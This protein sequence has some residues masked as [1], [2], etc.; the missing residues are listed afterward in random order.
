MTINFQRPRI[1]IEIRIAN[2]LR[3]QWSLGLANHLNYDQFSKIRR[4]FGTMVFYFALPI[5][6]EEIK[7][8]TVLILIH[9]SH[10]PCF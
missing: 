3:I 1:F 4:F 8:Q 7:A 6:A 5:R 2:P 9:N 10:Q